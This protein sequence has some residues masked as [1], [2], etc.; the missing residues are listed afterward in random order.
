ELYNG[1]CASAFFNPIPTL[2]HVLLVAA[3]PLINSYLIWTL[4]KQNVE[5]PTLLAWASLVSAGV[6]LFYAFVFAPLFPISLIGLLFVG[7]GLLPLSPI[8]ALWAIWHIRRNIIGLIGNRFPLSWKGLMVALLFVIVTIALS[9]VRI[10]KTRNA[11]IQAASSDIQQQNEGLQF[12]RNYGDDFFLVTLNRFPYSRNL[13]VTEAIESFFTTNEEYLENYRRE[14][15][16][17]VYYQLKGETYQETQARENKYVPIPDQSLQM[18]ASQ[19]DGSIDNEA[20]LG[21]LEWTFIYK[22][23]STWQREAVGEIKLPKNGVVSRL[24]LW[25]NGEEREAAFAENGRVIRAYN[26]VTAK[27]RDPVLV[28]K[29]G[30]DLI[31][32]KCFPVEPN[33]GEMKVRI[34]ITFPLALENEKSGLIQ[35][36]YFSYNN[37]SIPE[38]TKHIVW[39]ESKNSLESSN[40]NL[41]FERDNKVTAMRGNLSNDEIKALNATIRATRTE[42][43]LAWTK[44]ESNLVTQKIEIERSVKPTRFIFVIDISKRFSSEK[45][46]VISIIKNLPPESEVGLVLSGGSGLN[47]NLAFPNSFI[48]SPTEIAE[49]ITQVNFAGGTDN[50]PALTKAYQLAAEKEGSVIIALYAPQPFV[51]E[52]TFENKQF[53]TRRY[54]NQN[55]FR[56]VNSNLPDSI[57]SSLKDYEV[58]QTP[59]RY[60]DLKTD[61]EAF[62]KQLN[63]QKQSFKYVRQVVEN[64]DLSGA[65][66]TSKHLIRLWANDEV[67]R[68]LEAENNEKK[69]VE[70]AQKYQL[71]TPVTGAVVLETQQQ[72]EQFGLKPVDKNSVPTIPEPEI[73]LLIAIVLGVFLW[74]IATRKLF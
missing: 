27:R 72:Y 18:I 16:E 4:Y 19:I 64:A 21:Y 39:L 58:F 47:T 23:N 65:K 34:G 9:E 48:G 57:E 8:L 12:L 33:G 24:T 52:T 22:N 59:P 15:H 36:P 1:W 70:L 41:K 10:K 68:I 6:S 32:M 42:N 7:I 38:T 37:F 55:I 40:Q 50:M 26:A 63:E 61:V 71:V 35:L 29:A 25:I 20:S 5:K 11:I 54:N 30:K 53:F 44:D 73:Y 66:Q 28:T 74:L 67:S 45:E 14:N 46:N 43:K 17:Q 3:V 51:F 60:S 69:A 2:C 49:K 13:S 56:F 31:N 62:L